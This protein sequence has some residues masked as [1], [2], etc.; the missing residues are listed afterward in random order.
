MTPEES[1][2]ETDVRHDAAS[3]YRFADSVCSCCERRGHYPAYLEA[4][5]VFIDYVRDLGQATKRYLLSFPE[6]L[7][8]TPPS[9]YNET[10]QELSSLRSSWFALH[11]RL[12]PACDADTLHLPYPLIRALVARLHDIEMFKTTR[13]VVIHTE[14]L[15]YFQVTAAAC[16]RRPTTWPLLYTS[17]SS[18]RHLGL[19]EFHIRNLQRSY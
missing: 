8:R 9:E 14:R 5:R 11:R 13:F 12:K 7:A 6:K 3:L 15:N 19:S 4:N 18:T 2:P 1:R 17:K 10:R 16:R